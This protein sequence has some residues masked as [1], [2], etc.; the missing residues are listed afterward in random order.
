MQKTYKYH[1]EC[2]ACGRGFKT[3]RKNKKRC[4]P[5]CSERMKNADRNKGVGRREWKVAVP[6]FLFGDGDHCSYCGEPSQCIDHTIP[7]SFL[8]ESRKNSDPCGPMTYCCNFCNLTLGDKFFHTFLDRM[9]YVQKAAQDYA[10]KKFRNIPGWSNENILELD[11]TLQTYV[12]AKAEE[13]RKFD[14]MSTWDRTSKWG[15]VVAQIRDSPE[16]DEGSTKFVPFYKEF[17]DGLC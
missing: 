4:S 3:N 6:N 14:R 11:H 9:R 7:V 2:D 16:L 13:V 5:S 17:F 1:L 12:A 8:Q 15:K 10:R